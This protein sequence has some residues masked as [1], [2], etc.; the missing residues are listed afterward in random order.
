M[1]T[2]ASP[3]S[4]AGTPRSHGARLF[5][6]EVRGMRRITHQDLI[7]IDRVRVLGSGFR[8]AAM[9]RATAECLYLGCS[10]DV[11]YKSVFGLGDD[12][13]WIDEIDE[14]VDEFFE[15]DVDN[16]GKV[17]W[18]EWMHS[19]A[20]TVLSKENRLHQVLSADEKVAL[21]CIFKNAD[22][23]G[24]GMITRVEALS[25]YQIR[26]EHM[27]MHGIVPNLQSHERSEWVQRTVQYFFDA[28]GC[29]DCEGIDLDEFCEREAKFVI[30]D[31][32][33][34]QAN[35]AR[36]LAQR[37]DTKL[38]AS[39]DS[40][41]QPLKLDQARMEHARLLFQE[42]ARGINGMSFSELKGLLKT[43]RVGKENFPANR[44]RKVRKQAFKAADKDRNNRLNFVEFLAAYSF[45]YVRFGDFGVFAEA[46]D[47]ISIA[48]EDKK[49]RYFFN[50]VQLEN[51]AEELEQKNRH[52]LDSRLRVPTSKPRTWD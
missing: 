45:F 14:R 41:L 6:V 7:R 51:F 48:T 15:H 8:S 32:F 17:S 44:L 43:L 47:G 27:I 49:E 28:H 25:Y 11:R 26:L 23:N 50:P 39:L 36:K 5:Q 52:I 21:A 12:A 20:A 2:T 46:N 22:R 40:A 13:S 33:S 30:M 29:L 18:E 4:S 35:Q 3:K 31:R 10:H 1:G 42:H 19:K 24:D 38:G 9:P 34:K 37:F 16:D